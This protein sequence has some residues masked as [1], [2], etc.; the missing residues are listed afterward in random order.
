MK[1]ATI[2]EQEMTKIL[3]EVESGV[4]MDTGLS[5]VDEWNY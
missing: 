1:Q 5:R 4:S 2:K 3:R